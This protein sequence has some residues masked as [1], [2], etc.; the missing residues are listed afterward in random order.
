MHRRHAEDRK[1]SARALGFGPYV[2]EMAYTPGPFDDR[3]AELSRA[4]REDYAK[5]HGRPWPKDATRRLR[6]VK[7][8]AG[9]GG[10]GIDPVPYGA[11]WCDGPDPCSDCYGRGRVCSWC[12]HPEHEDA[13]DCQQRAKLPEIDTIDESP[14]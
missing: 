14:F 8:C 10:S 4:D 9:C 12:L 3:A 13:V 5:A 6:H 2:S 1:E 11:A 7:K